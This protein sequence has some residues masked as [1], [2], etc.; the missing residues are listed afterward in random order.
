MKK[1]SLSA[2]VLALPAVASAQSSAIES[3]LSNAVPYVVGIGMAVSAIGIIFAGIKYSSGDPQA[4]ETAKSVFI[5][6]VLIST[7][8]AVMGL[9]KALFAGR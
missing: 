5:G 3:G 2:L 7:G 8:S 9:I 6:A 4:K 1:A